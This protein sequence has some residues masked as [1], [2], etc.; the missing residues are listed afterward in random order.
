MACLVQIFEVRLRKI[1]LMSASLLSGLRVCAAELPV[2]IVTD[3]WQAVS[4]PAA[5]Q[6]IFHSASPLRSLLEWTNGV[7]SFGSGLAVA[8]GTP[9][10]PR[11]WLLVGAR[12]FRA[13]G[14]RVGGLVGMRHEEAAPHW[15]IDFDLAGGLGD[16]FYGDD[17]VVLRD[18]NGD[19]RE[20]LLVYSSRALAGTSFHAA[21]SLHLSQ[22]AGWQSEPAWILGSRVALLPGFGHMASA[23]DVNGDGFGDVV[24]GIPE[25]HGEKGIALVY[26]GSA[27]GLARAPAWVKTG[28]QAGE[29]FGYGVAGVGDV[30]GDG[31]D[32][33]FV[34][35]PGHGSE[36]SQR[37]RGEVFF[38]RASGLSRESSWTA[39]G[40]EDAAWFGDAA[41]AAGDINRD[42]CAD[43]FVSAPGPRRSVR[44]N[45]GWHGSVSV[46][47]G[48]PQ[49]AASTPVV[50]VQGSSDVSWFGRSFSR[51]G[52]MDG[53]GEIE[54]AVGAPRTATDASIQGRVEV[55]TVRRDFSI[56]PRIGIDGTTPG[57]RLGWRLA[58]G[59]FNGD[60]L[61]DLAAS[62][63]FHIPANPN[64]GHGMVAVVWGNREVFNRHPPLRA[65]PAL[66]K[67]TESGKEASP[68]RAVRH[69][70]RTMVWAAGAAGMVFAGAGALGWWWRRRETELVRRERQRIARDLH[71]QV[72]GHLTHLG[73]VANQERKRSSSA[74]PGGDA[75]QDWQVVTG[76]I[77]KGLSD[78]I[79]LARSDTQTLEALVD[80]MIDTATAWLEAAGIACRLDVPDTFPD[81]SVKAGV[82]QDVLL[83]FNES[84]NNLIRHAGATRADI[85]IRISDERWLEVRVQDDGRGFV[86]PVPDPAQGG[87]ANMRHRVESL[88]GQ[89][90][91]ESDSGGTC[92]RYRIPLRD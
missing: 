47:T 23:G 30:N 33:V 56:I 92:V 38:G 54:L 62:G 22:A 24:I 53:D 45:V 28:E 15:S 27:E 71:D 19:G 29:L 87:L 37:G 75:S 82:C 58:G 86:L 2:E 10:D 25:A 72:G 1:I 21:W 64:S 89:W 31:F 17:L 57:Q 32:D 78:A 83:V 65:E 39:S 84:I 90:K 79:W 44:R 77:Q 91:I 8:N 7:A 34:G 11:P 12:A 60:G 66:V 63:P 55:W 5:M 76:R 6:N 50:V 88:G 70:P 41:A 43:F 69:G 81:G 42:G 51:I 68:A 59:D 4:R 3:R 26:P 67:M 9:D 40:A 74:D 46:F 49:G 13:H 18:V 85:R 73:L 20:D 16:S 14:Q 48:S 35:A 61:A 80:R 52:D 36:N